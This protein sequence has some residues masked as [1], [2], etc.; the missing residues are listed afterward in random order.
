MV[1]ELLYE[2]YLR[3]AMSVMQVLISLRDNSLQSFGFQENKAEGEGRC[4][5][6]IQVKGRQDPAE[7][8]SE[9]SQDLRSRGASA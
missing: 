1:W 7:R 3:A 2:T 4:Q 9:K 6:S 5:V 8:Y